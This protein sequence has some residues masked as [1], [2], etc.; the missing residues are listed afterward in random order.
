ML[1]AADENEKP[2]LQKLYDDAVKREREVE[3]AARATSIVDQVALLWVPEANADRFQEKLAA[4]VAALVRL[5]NLEDLE[6][7]V[8]ALEQRNQELQAKIISLKQSQLSAPCPPNP[9]PA[10][11]PVSQSK[12]TLMARA[13]GTVT[14]AR[15]G[16]SS[17]SSGADS[18]AL[19]IVPNAGT[20][21]QNATVLT[22]V[23][24][25]GPVVDKRAA[26]LPSKYDGKADI[27]S[28][29]S[30]MRSYFEVMRT[31]QEDRSMI[32]GTN[33][34]P[35]VQSHIELQAVVAGYERI[36]LTEWLKV[37]PIRALE[38]LLIAR[39]QDKHAALKARLKLEALKGQTWRSSMQALEQHLTGLFTTPNLG[40]TDVSCMDVV[41]GVAP[42]EYLSLLALKDHT[43]W[44]ELM[45]DL[46]NLETKDLARRKK[47]PAA[48][49]KPQCKRYGSSNQLAQHEHR[50][51]EDQSYVDNLSLDDDLEPDSDMGCSTSAIDGIPPMRGVEHSIHLVPDYRVHYQAPYRLS[52]PE[53]TELKRQLEKLLRLG[54]I[55]PNN[56]PWGAP[57]LFARKAD[58][59]LRL[60]I[61]YR[62]LNC[63]TVKNNYPMPRTDEL[64]DRLADNRF[65]MKIDL[66]NG[67][68]RIRVAAENQPKTAFRSHFGHYEFTVTPFGLTN[69]P[70]T[71][72][73]AMN[74]IFRDILEKYVLVYLDDILVYSRT[75]ED[76]I[77]HLRDVLQ[78]LRKHGFYAKLIKCHFA[79]RKVDFLGHHV[80]DQGFHMDNAKIT[81]IAEW[82]S[83]HLPSSFAVS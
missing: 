49:G 14:G 7:R 71:F 6:S 78:C 73:T 29:I 82:L 37:T 22:G 44:R 58:G 52:I 63:Y 72:Q 32:M 28:W 5:R 12:T 13:S 62:G 31:P 17:S 18:S 11:V 48:G 80:S 41:M 26:T 79:Q 1:D 27:T 35:A 70:A 9:R 56:S 59:T 51:A 21:A 54:F 25:N 76:H 75:L 19:A 43:S 57:V 2:F 67:Y 34:E 10:A 39:Y 40:M 69:A 83:P 50:E 23:Q 46:V 68:H 30:S 33:T 55:K 65:F 8:T 74:N 20:S 3:A 47:A 45:M 81:A 77:R 15:T 16:A 36:D 4:A 60:C 42:K 53:A 61:D 66:R 38:D 24:Y 64:F